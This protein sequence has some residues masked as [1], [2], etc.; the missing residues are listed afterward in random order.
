MGVN[1]ARALYIGTGGE[2]QHC[3]KMRLNR[4]A[5]MF[6]KEEI[7]G[8]SSLYNFFDPNKMKHVLKKPLSFSRSF[9]IHI[10]TFKNLY[11]FRV[12]FYIHIATFKTLYLF[13]VSF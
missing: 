3:K 13:R 5:S 7:F 4:S 8:L 2:A 11:L 1:T 12:S 6:Q 10:G 9:Y